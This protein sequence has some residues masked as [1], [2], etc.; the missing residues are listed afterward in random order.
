MLLSKRD[1]LDRP[2]IVLGAIR[3]EPCAV[4]AERFDRLSRSFTSGTRRGVLGWLSTLSLG[5]GL[6]ALRG[7][8][9]DAK[10][11]HKHKKKKCKPKS[12]AKTCAGKC[13]AVKNNCKKTV[14]CGP[15]NCNPPCPVCQT[16]TGVPGICVIDPKQQGDACGAPGQVCQSAGTCTCVANSCAPPATCGGGGTPGVCGC[17]P[18]CAPGVC[19]AGAPD[20]CG[21]TR[22]CGACSGTTPICVGNVCTACSGTTPCPSGCCA[23]DGTC[24][25]GTGGGA[26]GSGGEICAVC[27]GPEVC[28]AGDCCTPVNP[29]CGA[30]SCNTTN[31]CGQP[32]NCCAQAGATNPGCEGGACCEQTVSPGSFCSGTVPCCQLGQPGSRRCNSGSC[33]VNSG[34]PTALA[35]QCCSGQRQGNFCV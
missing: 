27:G 28:F 32:V 21:G 33:C 13:G 11:R 19:G 4:D 18:T 29:T 2:R 24:Q 20:G 3:Q 35:V 16:C 5:G 6:A 26:C 23:G 25:P 31:N 15:C 14:D 7:D 9:V 1:H 12:R 30:T 10:G 17:T 22:N 34:F 8:E